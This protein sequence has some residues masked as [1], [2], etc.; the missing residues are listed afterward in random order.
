[1][2]KL[3]VILAFLAM[4]GT[5]GAAEHWTGFAGNNLWSDVGNW[6]DL[7]PSGETPGSGLSWDANRTGELGTPS[8]HVINVDV[9]GF[10]SSGTIYTQDGYT[11]NMT[12]QTGVT[13]DI[14]NLT[15]TNA[16]NSSSA[17]HLTVQPGAVLNVDEYDAT[18]I[19][20]RYCKMTIE[21][22]G[23]F[24]NDWLHLEDG[25]AVMD[26]YGVAETWGI[27]KFSDDPGH[28]INVR[29]GGRLKIG[30]DGINWDNNPNR[31]IGVY[32]LGTVQL[33]FDRTADYLDVVTNMEP[34][35]WVVDYDVTL[36]GYT[37]IKLVAP[38]W[39]QDDDNDV[40]MA[41][42]A[43]FQRCLTIGAPGGGPGSGCECYDV[44]AATARSTPGTWR[45]LSSAP[46]ERVFPPPPAAW[47]DR[48]TARWGR[49][50]RTSL[51]REREGRGDVAGER[52]GSLIA[53][54]RR[55][56][57]IAYEGRECLAPRV[58]Q[59]VIGHREE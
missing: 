14:Y 47:I 19:I 30:P 15:L 56:R 28:E 50:R 43:A 9:S 55:E 32:N 33:A 40:D 3:A 52:V 54:S 16:P 22:G 46:A 25:Y 1:M 49:C 23:Y 26:V 18:M 5:A 13:L 37:T 27:T 39:D 36:P 51:V 24:L 10:S 48:P 11:T 57:R 12:I 8:N 38:C 41:D 35:S 44:R 6:D 4:A 59:R 34:G 45:P 7:V 29:S 42:F 17:I 2:R 21:A 20:G 53:A 58:V 31:R